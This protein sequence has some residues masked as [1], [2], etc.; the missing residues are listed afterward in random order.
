[1]T[2][3][4]VYSTS[5]QTGDRAWLASNFGTDEPRSITL[6]ISG[7]TAAQ[8]FP[9]GYIPAGMILA[10][11]ASGLFAPYLDAGSGGLSTAVG[12]L[13]HDVPVAL[14]LVST[15]DIGAAM[16]EMGIIIAAKLPYTSGNAAA[17]G[18]LDTNGRADL[19]NWFK[20][21]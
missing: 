20:F 3:I 6:D 13:F 1:M 15:N 19:V 18:Y 10:Q 21:L 7:F 11:L 16:M 5:V 8:H 2:S 14:P 4:A 17:G 9:N 12:V